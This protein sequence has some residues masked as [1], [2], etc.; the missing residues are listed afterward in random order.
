MALTKVQGNM[1]DNPSMSTDTDNNLGLGTDA[2][3]S[4]TTG[5]DNVGIGTNALTSCTIGEDNVAVGVGA[6]Q[7]NDGTGVAG[8]GDDNT[9]VGRSAMQENTSGYMN[10]AFGTTALQKNTTGYNNTALGRGALNYCTTGY[11]NVGIGRECL[12]GDE[13]IMN[14]GHSNVAV[15]ISA[16]HDCQTGT[17]NVAIGRSSLQ[18]GTTGSNNTCIGKAAG[19]TI[20]TGSNNII[21]GK[22]AD[23]VSASTSDHLNI[24]DIIYGDLDDKNVGFGVTSAVVNGVAGTEGM[25]WRGGATNNYLAIAR[26]SSSAAIYLNKTNSDTTNNAMIVFKLDGS[27]VGGDIDIDGGAVRYNTTSDYR[28]KENITPMTGSVA[29]VNQLNPTTYNFTAFT[30]STHEGFLAHELQEVLP[31]AV[32]GS[33]NAVDSEGNAEYQSV[34][35]SKLVPLLV[36]AIQE[37][38]TEI[39]ILK[40][41]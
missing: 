38:S 32:S 25:W 19:N 18:F 9:A 33:K 21:I 28:L 31:S 17:E 2:V 37:L 12:Y 1:V 30:N 3:N 4:I 29:R 5:N 34:D 10:T 20:T 35:Y 24:G 11:D 16:H 7:F 40:N 41:T 27:V 15:G 22:D 14:T 39:D 13:I 6:L 26:N 8:E 36:S 23:V